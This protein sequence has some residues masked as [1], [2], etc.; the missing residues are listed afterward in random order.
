[1]MAKQK[2]RAP[3]TRGSSKTRRIRDDP[4]MEARRSAR[5]TK[6]AAKKMVTL[7][8]AF[9]KV[10]HEGVASLEKG[11][12]EGLADAIKQER[13]IIEAQRDLIEQSV[14]TRTLKR[15]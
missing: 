6:A 5:Q 14:N 11:D 12:F 4:V 7:R 13:D 1:M 3:K 15:K 2:Q 8:K 9:G 10:H